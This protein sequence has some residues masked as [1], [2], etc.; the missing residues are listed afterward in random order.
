MTHPRYSPDLARNDFWLIRK[1]KCELSGKNIYDKKELDE[2][3][4][5]LT[6]IPA[7]EYVRCYS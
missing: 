4:K 5:I 6:S 1:V 2:V 3:M 7:E